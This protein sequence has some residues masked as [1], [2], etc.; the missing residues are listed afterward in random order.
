LLSTLGWSGA[1]ATALLNWTW[2]SCCLPRAA[3]AAPR[4]EL[5]RRSG[6]FGR[7]PDAA[8]V[9][10]SPTGRAQGSRARAPGSAREPLP[11]RRKSQ[12]PPRPRRRRRVARAWARAAAAAAS[13]PRS[14]LA[15]A[16]PEPLRCE[17]VGAE[18]LSS[19]DGQAQA[20]SPN[21]TANALICTCGGERWRVQTDKGSITACDGGRQ[22]ATPREIRSPGS[23]SASR[24]SPLSPDRRPE[25]RAHVPGRGAVSSRAQP[26][27]GAA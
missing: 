1:K 26:T 22:E 6:V 23:A 15:A 10:P 13:A 9:P 27:R 18:A 25:H 20:A 19:A 8:A 7:L 14:A 24:L 16:L 21:P 12:A 2:A 11:C 3:S 17:R 4:A 5:R